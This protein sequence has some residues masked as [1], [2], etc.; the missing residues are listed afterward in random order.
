ME[1]NLSHIALIGSGRKGEPYT[2]GEQKLAVDV[3]T[4]VTGLL[5]RPV[6]GT[7]EIPDEVQ[8]AISEVSETANKSVVSICRAAF[9]KV[10]DAH[11]DDDGV[12]LEPTKFP[13][14][15]DWTSIGLLF[16]HA[17]THPQLKGAYTQVEIDSMFK[18]YWK[19]KTA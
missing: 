18:A 9:S 17:A 13:K 6:V 10:A 1:L 2:K 5:G 4:Q 14:K 19:K 12:A 11:F 15:R 7:P 16:R 3:L 8:V